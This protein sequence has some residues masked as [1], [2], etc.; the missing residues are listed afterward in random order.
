MN[1]TSKNIRAINNIISD[2]IGVTTTNTRS[3]N[4]WAIL[5][6][7]IN[8]MRHFVHILLN[9]AS[10]FLGII[11]AAIFIEIEG[12]IKKIVEVVPVGILLERSA[13]L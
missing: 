6:R 1:T 12:L 9:E 3:K 5:T 11:R 8:G 7:R 4:I 10:T 13:M 2:K